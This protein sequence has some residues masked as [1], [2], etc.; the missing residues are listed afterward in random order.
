MQE[1]AS[2]KWN[3]YESP[4]IDARIWANMAF[5][6]WIFER[7]F[8]DTLLSVLRK[9]KLDRYAHAKKPT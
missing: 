6:R 3:N 9:M 8:W 7:R 5:K 2:D 4:K 1:Q